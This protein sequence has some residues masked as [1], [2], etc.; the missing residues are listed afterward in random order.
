MSF[1]VPILTRTQGNVSINI[2]TRYERAANT[3]S[4]H[5][6]PCYHGHRYPGLLYLYLYKP[7]LITF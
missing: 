7:V 2:Q 4:I 3:S 5:T 6:L 1:F